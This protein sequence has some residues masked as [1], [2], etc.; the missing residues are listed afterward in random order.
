[1]CSKSSRTDLNS[2]IEL[3]NSKIEKMEE[4]N[5]IEK[6]LAGPLVGAAH[7]PVPS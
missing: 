4:K 1:M 3:Q 2:N 5:K 7:E 6:E